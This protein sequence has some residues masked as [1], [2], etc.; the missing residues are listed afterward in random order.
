MEKE[1][2]RILIFSVAYLPFV[3]GA[4]VAVKELT[5]RLTD[6]YFDLVTVNLDGRQ[7]KLET[8]GRVNVHRVGI[9]KICKYT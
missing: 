2:K 7:K 1:K 6:C 8:I 4:E 3:G 9:S 5:D